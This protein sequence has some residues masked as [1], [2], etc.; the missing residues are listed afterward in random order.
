VFL[1]RD[2]TVGERDLPPVGFS[3]KVVASARCAHDNPWN[4]T[5]DRVDGTYLAGGTCVG[6]DVLTAG[7]A[8]E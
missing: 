5:F 7:I 2:Q 1:R 3:E 8:T 4:D 6:V